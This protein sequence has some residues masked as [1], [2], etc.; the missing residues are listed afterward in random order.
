MNHHLPMTLDESIIRLATGSRSNDVGIASRRSKVRLNCIAKKFLVTITPKT[1]GVT[2]G[3]SA[4][5]IKS[6]A[7]VR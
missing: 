1:F 3:F 5:E 4:E 2:P 6:T 7:N